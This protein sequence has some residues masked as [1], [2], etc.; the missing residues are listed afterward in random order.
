MLLVLLVFLISFYLKPRSSRGF[1]LS[2]SFLLISMKP[3]AFFLLLKQRQYLFIHITSSHFQIITCR[4]WSH[5]SVICKNQY[6]SDAMLLILLALK[7]LFN[8]TLFNLSL[9]DSLCLSDLWAFP[10]KTFSLYN[11]LTCRVEW[12]ICNIFYAVTFKIVGFYWIYMLEYH[13]L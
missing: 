6:T 1:S 11:F 7:K 10:L 13:Q 4:D 5:S 2:I 9:W 12:F 3:I 8:K